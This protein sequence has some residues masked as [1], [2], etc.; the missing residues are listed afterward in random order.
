MKYVS[1]FEEMDQKDVPRFGG[2]NAALG[3]MIQQL[4]RVGITIPRGFATTADAYWRHI[5]ENNLRDKIRDALAPVLDN[6]YTRDELKAVGAQVRELIAGAPIPEDVASEIREAYRQLSEMY[7]QKELDVAVRS[8]ATAEDLPTASFAGQ[9]ET[10]LN[11]AGEDE[12]LEACRKS[13]ASLFTDR[14]IVYRQE[15]G[16]SHFEVA[17]SV[18]VQKMV[19]ADKACSGVLFTLDPDTGFK[20]VVYINAAYGLGETVVQGEV[21]PDEYMVHKPMTEKGFRPII[22]KV[23]GSKAIQRIYADAGGLTDV[24]VSG[25][26]QHQFTLTDDE[27]M[28]LARDAI[29]IENH[30]SELHE[31]WSPMDIEWAKDGIDGRLYIVQAR[32]ETV[33]SQKHENEITE[34]ALD[35]DTQPEPILTGIA[36]GRGITAGIVRKARTIDDITVFD[37]GDI[38]VTE[39]TDPDWVP[40][41]KQAGAIITELGGR[42][43]HAAIVSRELGIPA[44]IGVSDALATLTD[45]Q[46]VTVDCIHGAIGSIYDGALPFTQETYPVETLPQ[47]PVAIYMNVG[48]PDRAFALSF[49]PVAGVGLARLEFIIS[50]AIQIHPLAII[51]PD[52]VK[53][54]AITQKIENKARSYESPREYFIATLAEAIGQIVAAFYPRPVIVRLTDFKTNEYRGLL[55]GQYFEPEEENPML[56]FRGASRYVSESYEE[57]FALECAALYRVW[58]TMGLDTMQLMVPFVR[59]INEAQNVRYAINQ[60]GLAALKCYMMVEVPSNVL[61][62]VD[63]AKEFD[64]F[65]IGSND[66]TQLVL[67]VDRDAEHL[68]YL[69]DERDEAVKQACRLTIERAH[70]VGIPVSICGQ[71]PSDFPEFADFLIAAGIDALS[72]SPDAVIPFMKRFN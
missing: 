28:K 41:M 17:L 57:A 31:R 69:F 4:S 48:Q 24:S 26:R 46:E 45:E 68:S 15:K 6:E 47:P 27:I 55:G 61:Q 14:A 1:F 7:A 18:G 38:L 11:I 44:V 32:P 25:E 43:S 13:M 64:G 35:V 34:Y 71:A 56:G 51:H 53:D 72:L 12:L 39:M 70:A 60:Q 65:S 3:Q 16:F 63:F 9:Q 58:H 59:T 21:N 40:L 37:D 52:R 5:D 23:C 36:I 42:T 49:Y 19:R 67:G 66:L 33:Y 8:S 20:D 30:Y 62:A 10:F 29:A 50:N 2:K 54:A 22:R